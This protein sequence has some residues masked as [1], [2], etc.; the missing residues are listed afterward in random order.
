ML[1]QAV[2]ASGFGTQLSGTALAPDATIGKDG[3]GR[4][5]FMNGSLAI[6]FAM[7]CGFTAAG[8]VASLYRVSQ[9]GEAGFRALFTSP[10]QV[11]WSFLLCTFAG[12]WIILSAALRVWRV[13]RMPTAWLAFSAAVAA[14]W[15]FCSGVVIVQLSL[16]AGLAL[17]A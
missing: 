11:L 3:K 14:T 15:S 10:S 12:P 5:N 8:F 9:G 6:A 17:Q 7:A 2:V 4:V 16:L 1:S 13:G